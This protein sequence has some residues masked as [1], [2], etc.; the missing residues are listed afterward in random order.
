MSNIAIKEE[1]QDLLELMEEVKEEGL[2]SVNERPTLNR[3]KIVNHEKNPKFKKGT[4]VIGEKWNEN[5]VAEA[6]Y[7][8]K[9]IIILDRKNQYAY[10]SD[11]DSTKNCISK[12]FDY[13]DPVKPRGNYYGYE[14][15]KTCPIFNADNRD[16]CKANI[17]LFCL[18][19]IEVD[20]KREWKDC[21]YY[22]KG[23]AWMPT[24]DY[25]KK[26]FQVVIDGKLNNFATFFFVTEVSSEAFDAGAN[27]FYRP[28]YKRGEKLGREEINA[29][30]EMVREIRNKVELMNNSFGSIGSVES[31]DVEVEAIPETPKVVKEEL[32]PRAKFTERLNVGVAEVV[33]QVE[34]EDDIP[35]SIFEQKSSGRDSE[36]IDLKAT[37][38]K[39]LQG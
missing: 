8:V 22:A 31:D 36:I 21:V 34:D 28:V 18:A 11:K 1:Y 25:L 4:W 35:N 12:L 23:N 26:A 27:V 19:E 15:G 24:Y 32:P 6:G 13:G 29:L 5:K 20:G 10:Y 33:P 14:C 9:R 3:L 17:V 39:I 38:S 16:K 2:V 30:K 37:I 7:E